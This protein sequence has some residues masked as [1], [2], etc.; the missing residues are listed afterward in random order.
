VFYALE[1]AIFAGFAIYLW[2]RLVR[3]VVEREAEPATGSPT[4]E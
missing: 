4:V 3:D 2:Y 1:W